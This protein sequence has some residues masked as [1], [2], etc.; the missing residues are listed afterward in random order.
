MEGRSLS[1][2][3]VQGPSL[4]ASLIIDKLEDERHTDTGKEVDGFQSLGAQDYDDYPD[5]GFRAWLIVLGTSCC[6]FA[7]SGFLNSWGV[8]QSYYETNILRDS[9]PSQ[10]AWIGSIQ[11]ALVFLP[12][13]VTGR[14]FDLGHFKLPFL[15]GTI[16]LV[17]STFL[18]AECHAYWHF[19]LC[20]GFAVGLGSG[21]CFGPTFGVIGHWFKRRRG[22]AVG[23]TAAAASTG[24]TVFPIACRNLIRL[25]GFPWTMRIMG[26]MILFMLSISNITLIR[27]LPP[28][29]VPG[30][31]F[32]FNAFK[33]PA[34]SVYCLANTVSFLGVFTVL[35]FIDVSAIAAGISPEFS[36]YLVSL[37]NAG[38]GVGRIVTGLMAD[39][40]GAINFMVPMTIGVAIMTFAWPY[41]QT[42][43]S[44]TVVA[45]LYG[46]ASSACVTA[47]T[48]P[49]YSMG[50]IE[51]V[52]RR[53]GTVM[54]FAALGSIAGPPISGA[55]N[56]STG[57]IKAVSYYAGSIMLLAVI[58]LL[59][60]R[61][62]S[63]KKLWGKF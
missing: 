24:G 63:L 22:I 3:S 37:A 23:I 15:L 36:F 12:G 54:V 9:S 20:Q 4:A 2:D 35:T 7:T 59:V 28:K 52:G 19:L 18:V 33:M 27:R 55:I 58:L 40:Y 6:A 32:N 57:G 60:T 5:G 62:L 29:N 45:I 13:Q 25:V 14:M 26:F 49:L 46:F 56:A 30:G 61:H 42:K 31:L 47:F 8:F 34:F 39:R 17:V 10:I 50:V 16:L 21:I 51:D 38:S 44:L 48:M 1:I 53:I 43:G 11:Y 41:A